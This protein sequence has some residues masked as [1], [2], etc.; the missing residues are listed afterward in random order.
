[1]QLLSLTYFIFIFNL[2][3]S[4]NYNKILQKL[5]KNICLEKIIVKVITRKKIPKQSDKA[6]LL[7]EKSN[8]YEK[9]IKRRKVNLLLE[10]KI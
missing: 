5:Q 9:P 3:K 4:N 6:F 8:Y 2:R 10:K 7:I 1:M